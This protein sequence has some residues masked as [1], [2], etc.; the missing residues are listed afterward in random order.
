MIYSWKP[1]E[2]HWLMRCKC[3]SGISEYIN[4]SRHSSYSSLYRLPSVSLLAW[5]VCPLASLISVLV[6][7]TLYFI[8]SACRLITDT[9]PW[10]SIWFKYFDVRLQTAGEHL[11]C[12]TYYDSLFVALSFGKNLR[13]KTKCKFAKI[14]F[15]TG[16]QFSKRVF[17]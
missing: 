5:F 11:N 6:P 3:A 15:W 4:T 10:L 17:C 8:R 7:W 16:H 12:T 9:W 2:V 14:D 1:N 13:K